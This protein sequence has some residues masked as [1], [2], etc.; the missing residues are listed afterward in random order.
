M[1][2]SSTLFI[3][4]GNTLRADDSIAHELVERLDCESRSC[5]QLTPE[6]AAEMAGFETVIFLDADGSVL[7]PIL[8]P[9]DESA[10]SRPLTHVSSPAEVVA[11][12]RALFDFRGH[13]YQL[14]LPASDFSYRDGLS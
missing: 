6:I 7:E 11:L 1:E 2:K 8:E 14:R 4:I 12:A 10:S 5:H 3:A 13:A 9:V